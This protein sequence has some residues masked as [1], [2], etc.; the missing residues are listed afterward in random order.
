LFV[1]NER[2]RSALAAAGMTGRE[3][4]ARLGVDAKT[5]DR[6]I[7]PGRTP[8]PGNCYEAARLL[9]VSAV[10]LWP[11]LA[12]ESSPM[13]GRAELI[14]LYPHRSAAPKGLWR[15]VVGRAEAGID[16]VAYAGL[17]FTEDAP[18]VIGVLRQKAED[19]VR[20]R[21]A[22]GDP[23]SAEVALRGEEEGLGEAIAGRI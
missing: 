16:I 9:D 10:W 18:E 8:H 21:I 17:F 19:G 12:R 6:W 13:V 2:L 3:L 7:T 15:E 20:V 4:A 5:V 1:A 23:D 11:D 22:L 14:E